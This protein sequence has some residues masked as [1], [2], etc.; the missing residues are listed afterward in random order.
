MAFL[1]LQQ[2]EP[3]KKKAMFWMGLAG[4]PADAVLFFTADDP[5][6]LQLIGASGIMVVFLW[7]IAPEF[8]SRRIDKYL[9]DKWRKDRRA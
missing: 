4:V 7:M 1:L 8:I 2:M 9:P 3:W 5:S 6:K